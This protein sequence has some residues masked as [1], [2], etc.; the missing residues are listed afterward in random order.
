MAAP[1]WRSIYETHAGGAEPALRARCRV[2]GLAHYGLMLSTKTCT[3][4]FG[5]ALDGHGAE[6]VFVG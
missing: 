6:G 5:A 2:S 1:V 3:T 4:L